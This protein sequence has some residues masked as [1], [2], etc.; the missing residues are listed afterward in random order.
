MH[1]TLIDWSIACPWQEPFTRAIL[2]AILLQPKIARVSYR[3]FSGDGFKKITDQFRL[4]LAL[5]S[6]IA[7]CY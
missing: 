5:F 2:S 3:R 4:C 7:L 6:F 1:Q